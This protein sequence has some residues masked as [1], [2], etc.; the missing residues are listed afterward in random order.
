MHVTHELWN[1]RVGVDEALRKFFGVR[2]GVADAFN[3]GDLGHVVEQ[4]REVGEFVG[5]AH[6]AKVRVD[7]LAQQRHFAH[8][9][10]G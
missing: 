8:A 5:I 3:A 1:A 4:Q 7:V 9:L 10:V 6:A 2:C